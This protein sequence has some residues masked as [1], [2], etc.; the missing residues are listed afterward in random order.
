MSSILD[1]LIPMKRSEGCSWIYKSGVERG[2]WT[3]NIY[4]SSVI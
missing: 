2:M 1:M 4:S 3:G